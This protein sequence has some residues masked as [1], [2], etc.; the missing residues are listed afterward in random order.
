MLCFAKK[1]FPTLDFTEALR[2]CFLFFVSFVTVL[3][4]A[5]TAGTSHAI[6]V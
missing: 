6:F 2:K 4:C 3:T 5:L 1:L